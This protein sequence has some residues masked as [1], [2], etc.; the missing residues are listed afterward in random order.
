MAGAEHTIRIIVLTPSGFFCDVSTSESISTPARQRDDEKVSPA[1]PSTGA[2][3]TRTVTRNAATGKERHLK[4]AL[5]IFFNSSGSFS[6]FTITNFRNP[7]DFASLDPAANRDTKQ[8]QKAS[9]GQLTRLA[10]TS[11]ARYRRV[12]HPS[13]CRGL[14]ASV[15]RNRRGCVAGHCCGTSPG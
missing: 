3:G 13:T 14:R 7:P 6:P 11:Q 1:R 8:R 15:T 10:S 9:V 2:A 4:A 5:L 12:D